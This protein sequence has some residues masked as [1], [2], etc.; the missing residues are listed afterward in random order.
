MFIQPQLHQNGGSGLNAFCVKSG[1]AMSSDKAARSRRG[2]P[3]FNDSL[4]IESVSVVPRILVRVLGPTRVHTYQKLT[5]VVS[6]IETQFPHRA[7]DKCAS[8][9]LA[10]GCS[11][12]EE[13]SATSGIKKSRLE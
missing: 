5:R 6:S 2:I 10:R 9:R 3:S 8:S 1:W 4:R 12:K 7:E 11:Q 13:A